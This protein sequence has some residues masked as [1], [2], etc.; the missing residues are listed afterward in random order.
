M[1][2]RNILF[3]TIVS[4]LISIS[5]TAHS[6]NNI[7]SLDNN[8]FIIENTSQ[9]QNSTEALEFDK[10]I[11]NLGRFSINSGEK[12]CSFTFKNT[13]G[14]PL[15]INS[16]LSS[17]GCTKPIWPKKPIMPNE[18]GK[19]DVTYSNDQGP[20]PIDK[21]ITVYTSASAKPIILRITGLPY[22][23]N[24]TLKEQFPVAIGPLGVVN[25]TFKLGQIA[26]GMSKSGHVTIANLSKSAVTLTFTNL[27]NGL[28]IS[29]E[30]KTIPANGMGEISYTVN[31]AASTNW[32]IT[33]F[34]ATAVCNGA[35]ASTPLYI[36]TMI[37]DNF[38]QLT[39]EQKNKSPMIIAK[40]SS[41]NFGE[42]AMNKTINSEF[43]LR[44][45]GYSTLK[46]Y[47]VDT[48]G[49]KINVEFPK[50]VEAGEEFSIKTSFVTG[51]VKGDE[52]HTLTIITNSPNRPLVNLFV[53]GNVK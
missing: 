49:S 31:T 14:K 43:K 30:P 22:G 3:F 17:C 41:S 8:L 50:E 40:N 38:S 15:V 9:Q 13:S 29:C 35:K 32:G 21:S 24:K 39:K 53:M 23:A 44:N 19:I 28:T 16:V 33:K 7:A 36:E 25:N 52:I 51:T 11:C 18:S 26:Q 10:K 46:I 47:K 5:S 48:N 4:A 6:S 27:S 12:S 45:S 2:N 1:R 37:I 20:Y 42:S 34:K